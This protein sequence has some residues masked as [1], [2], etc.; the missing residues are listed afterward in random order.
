MTG[1]WSWAAD[2]IM[3]AISPAMGKNMAMNWRRTRRI[4]TRSLKLQCPACGETPLYQSPFRMWSHCS[5][6]GYIFEREQGYFIGAIYAN[7]IATE[8][9]L[10]AV[11]LALLLFTALTNEATTYLLLIIGVTFPLIFF[12]HSR[13]LWLGI[14]YLLMPPHE[15]V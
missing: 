11:Y 5:N 13:S 10:V 9:V 3:F 14:D 8:T 6:C 7:V 1:I 2:Y 15:R 4:L 12:H